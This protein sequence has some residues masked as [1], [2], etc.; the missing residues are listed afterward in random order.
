VD[1]SG[2]GADEADLPLLDGR[3]RA[4]RLG[5]ALPIMAAVGVLAITVLRRRLG[6]DART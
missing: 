5:P 3:T 6:P 1:E 4:S 2:A